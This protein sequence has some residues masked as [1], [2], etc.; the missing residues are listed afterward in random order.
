MTDEI[1]KVLNPDEIET[2]EYLQDL[3]TDIKVEDEGEDEELST[4]YE[5][6][7]EEVK[8]LASEDLEIFKNILKTDAV[9][10]KMD[11]EHE[12]SPELDRKNK[13]SKKKKV[14]AKPEIVLDLSKYGLDESSSEFVIRSDHVDD[15]QLMSA[16]RTKK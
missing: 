6:V 3:K 9:E 7:L 1:E 10:Q 8:S 16:L 11:S 15:H 2:E 12:N 5:N 4:E 14:A 13:K